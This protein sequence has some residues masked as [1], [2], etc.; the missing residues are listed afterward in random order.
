MG[1]FGKKP[2]DLAKTSHQDVVDYLRDLEQADYTKILKVVSTYR[3][4]DKK[5]K[6]ILNIK[7]EPVALDFVHEGLL[8]DDGDTELGDYLFDD[9]PPKVKA[10][11]TEKPKK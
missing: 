6:K 9:P 7:Y 4:A 3:E 10:N 2:A 11:K 8:I 1:L 5:V